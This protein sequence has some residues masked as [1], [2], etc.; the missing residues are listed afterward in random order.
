VPQCSGHL[1]LLAASCSTLR[2]TTSR[3]NAKLR[4]LH[5][6]RG[7]AATTGGF[8]AETDNNQASVEPGLPPSPL[9]HHRGTASKRGADTEENRNKKRV[10]CGIFACQSSAGRCHLIVL[11]LEE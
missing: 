7:V 9:M 11:E 3:L 2:R 4:L 1:F 5:W 8:V 10:R 6:V